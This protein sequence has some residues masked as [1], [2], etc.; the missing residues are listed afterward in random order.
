MVSDWEGK[1]S[2]RYSGILWCLQ[3]VGRGG[4]GRLF[5]LSVA[6]TQERL[7]L[8]GIERFEGFSF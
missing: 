5:S 3:V 1:V 8:K 6:D 4:E 7:D 2:L